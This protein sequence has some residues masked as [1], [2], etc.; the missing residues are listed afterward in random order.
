MATEEQLNV[1]TAL[2][3]MVTVSSTVLLRMKVQILFYCCCCYNK[4]IIAPCL[5]QAR[6]HESAFKGLPLRAMLVLVEKF[7]NSCPYV[8]AGVMH[9]IIPYEM[10]HAAYVDMGLGRFRS[11][12][13]GQ[14]VR[15]AIATAGRSASVEGEGERE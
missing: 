7:V 12:E 14:T 11:A 10:M 9:A 4:N 5:S 15:G 2:H 3:Q 1:Q 6:Q 8:N 13:A